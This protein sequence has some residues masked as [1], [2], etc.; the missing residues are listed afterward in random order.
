MLTIKTHYIRAP[1]RYAKQ[2]GIDVDA[3]LAE[4]DISPEVFKHETT[5][6]HVSQY[7]RLVQRVG[8]YR[9]MNTLV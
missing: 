6:V 1:L 4:L 7:V 5:L 3:L 9:V 2:L 8:K